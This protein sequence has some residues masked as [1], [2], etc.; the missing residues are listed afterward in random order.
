MVGDLISRSALLNRL[1]A[2]GNSRYKTDYNN[3]WDDAR[4]EIITT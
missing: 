4:N 3:G 2:Y 1:A